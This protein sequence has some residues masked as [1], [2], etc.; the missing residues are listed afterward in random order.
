MQAGNIGI[1]S[2]LGAR[3]DMLV[4]QG[5]IDTGGFL[6]LFSHILN[7]VKYECKITNK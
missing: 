4:H 5:I 2:L 1:E 6:K 3:L 7:S